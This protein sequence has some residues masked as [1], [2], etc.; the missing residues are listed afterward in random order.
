MLEGG[1]GCGRMIEQPISGKVRTHTEYTQFCL[2][3]AINKKGGSSCDL[4]EDIMLQ[5]GSHQVP[6]S[7]K[8]EQRR[9][10]PGQAFM[11]TRVPFSLKL[12]NTCPKPDQPCVNAGKAKSLW[13][14]SPHSPLGRVKL[15]QPTN[16]A[17]TQQTKACVL[18]TQGA[19]I[20]ITTPSINQAT[21]QIIWLYLRYKRAAHLSPG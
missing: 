8:M 9:R 19:Q 1:Q 16:K 11:G 14:C 15:T 21:S 20:L 10:G 12:C 18:D 6:N 5:W 3:C 4:L 17:S 13:P 2:A 7:N